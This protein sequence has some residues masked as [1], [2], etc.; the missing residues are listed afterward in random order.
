MLRE[1]HIAHAAKILEE[2]QTSRKR[3]ETLDAAADLKMFVVKE[4]VSIAN[5]CP[6]PRIKLQALDHLYKI[7]EG[8]EK[9][10]K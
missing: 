1:D 3:G 5:E 4:L 6:D 2:I 7:A 8:M 10:S 9:T